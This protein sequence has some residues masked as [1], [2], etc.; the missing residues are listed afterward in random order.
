MENLQYQNIP[1]AP[2]YCMKNDDKKVKHC[3]IDIII[4]DIRASIDTGQI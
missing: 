2:V 1:F 3:L 4:I